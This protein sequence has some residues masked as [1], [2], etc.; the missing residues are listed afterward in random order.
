MELINGAFLSQRAQVNRLPQIVQIRQVVRPPAIQVAQHNFPGSILSD[1]AP[2][3]GFHFLRPRRCQLGQFFPGSI[4]SQQFFPTLIQNLALVA[5]ELV[6]LP[7]RRMN[8]QHGRLCHSLCSVD[9]LVCPLIAD[10][11]VV[12]RQH[13]QC[14]AGSTFGNHRVIQ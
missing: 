4:R 10:A 12:F 5:D 1:F 3:C 9:K 2:D 14:F 7:R 13:A 8:G 6:V 11:T